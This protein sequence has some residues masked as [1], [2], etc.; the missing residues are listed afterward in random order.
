MTGN[1][2]GPKDNKWGALAAGFMQAQQQ[3]QA[4]AQMEA[5]QKRKAALEELQA[6]R[7]MIEMLAQ[8]DPSVMGQPWFQQAYMTGDLD[9]VGQNYTPQAAPVKGVTLADGGMLVN[10]QTGEVMRENAKAPG[11]QAVKTATFGGKVHQLDPQTGKW[12]PLGASEGALGRN[13]DKTLSPADQVK[14]MLLDRYRNGD[15]S[16]EVLKGLS[17]YVAPETEKPKKYI[18]AYRTTPENV[19]VMDIIDPDTN[20]VVKTVDIGAVRA[21]GFDLSG[22]FGSEGG[23]GSGAAEGSTGVT[24]EDQAFL[25][26]LALLLKE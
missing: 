2:F 9:I 18:R 7:G 26:Q 25:D 16:P 11:T 20:E 6:N 24:D 17:M 10:P 14:Q 3:K 12:L 15:H 1:E 23:Y 5:E 13:R 19:K 21:S 4:Q 8:K 22:L